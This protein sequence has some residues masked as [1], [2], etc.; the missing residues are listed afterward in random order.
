LFKSKEGQ[1]AK[2]DAMNNG[3]RASYDQHRPFIT[4]FI[5]ERFSFPDSR[6]RSD[7]TIFEA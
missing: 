2:Y 4:G 5:K 3:C 1:K 7:K 6:Q